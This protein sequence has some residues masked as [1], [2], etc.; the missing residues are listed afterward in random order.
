MAH[1]AHRKE[2]AQR[3]PAG[4]SNACGK[5]AYHSRKDARRAARR[6]P[7]DHLRAYPCPTCDRFHIGHLSKAI[8]KGD[9]TAREIYRRAS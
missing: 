5:V 2:H 4:A 9:F 6:Y 1:Q 7:A 3:R 8:R